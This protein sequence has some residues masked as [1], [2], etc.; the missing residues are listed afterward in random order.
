[1]KVILFTCTESF[2]ELTSRRLGFLD[3]GISSHSL[4]ITSKKKKKQSDCKEKPM[5]FITIVSNLPHLSYWY[6]VIE[7]NLI[8]ALRN[9]CWH[10]WKCPWHYNDDIVKL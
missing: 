1:M 9:T 8:Y 2:D 4:D 10:A 7:K 3:P 6:Y 5:P